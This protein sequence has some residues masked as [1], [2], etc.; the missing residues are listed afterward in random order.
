MWLPRA[1]AMQTGVR[2]TNCAKKNRKEIKLGSGPFLRDWKLSLL[3]MDTT[4]HIRVGIV[5]HHLGIHNADS[6]VTR[7]VISVAAREIGI[8]G[9]PEGVT[10]VRSH[11][12]RAACA[13]T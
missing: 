1:R 8:R 13:T 3:S 12:A 10:A 2:G 9:S 6:L 11:L 5:S 7:S 4:K